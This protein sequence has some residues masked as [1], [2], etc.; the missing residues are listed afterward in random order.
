MKAADRV[1]SEE[2]GSGVFSSFCG[3]LPS[4][5]RLELLGGRVLDVLATSW[6]SSRFCKSSRSWILNVLEQ[7]DATEMGSENWPLSDWFPGC[8]VSIVL[9]LLRVSPG[10][11]PMSEIGFSWSAIKEFVRDWILGART[12]VALFYCF[13]IDMQTQYIYNKLLQVLYQP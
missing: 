13:L 6:R 10:V 11:V 2:K 4:N 3:L 8:M 5:P 12:T 9:C 1:S 7:D